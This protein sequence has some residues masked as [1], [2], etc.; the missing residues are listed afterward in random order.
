[1]FTRHQDFARAKPSAATASERF[2]ATVTA[3]SRLRLI[4]ARVRASIAD[5][6]ATSNLR[7]CLKHPSSMEEGIPSNLGN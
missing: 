2:A 4:V 1:M 3:G 5:V 7:H 6:R